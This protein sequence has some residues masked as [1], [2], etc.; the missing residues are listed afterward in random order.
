LY[1]QSAL[2][3]TGVANIFF[4]AVLS[5]LIF[6]VVEP[7]LFD[8]EEHNDFHVEHIS[9]SS[10]K[11]WN[12]YLGSFFFIVCFQS[13]IKKTTENSFTGLAVVILLP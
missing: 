11:R 3:V 7:Y 13:K 9:L 1:E 8:R 2:S 12:L 10:C 6:F 5:L 4:Q